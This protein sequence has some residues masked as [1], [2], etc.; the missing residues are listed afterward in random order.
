MHFDAL[1]TKWG[2]EVKGDVF[3]AL[4]ENIRGLETRKK[5]SLKTFLK[6]APLTGVLHGSRGHLARHYAG[7]GSP[8]RGN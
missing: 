3:Q 2:V 7:K 1:Q 4:I 8:R 5:M 6:G